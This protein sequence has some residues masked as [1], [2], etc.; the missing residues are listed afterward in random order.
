MVSLG[1][2]SPHGGRR[3]QDDKLSSCSYAHQAAEALGVD[4]RTVSRDLAR[5]KK[6]APEVMAEVAATI[7]DKG[8]SGA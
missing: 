1:L 8:V 4:K 2:V 7:L 5:G 3:N 6:I